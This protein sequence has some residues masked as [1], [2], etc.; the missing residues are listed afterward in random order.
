MVLSYRRL[1]ACRG[2]RVHRAVLADVCRGR[3]RVPR[4]ER[5]DVEDRHSTSREK[6]PAAAGIGRAAPPARFE[7]ADP[8]TRAARAERRAQHDDRRSVK[9]DRARVI[10]CDMWAGRS[11]VAARWGAVAARLGAVGDA[12]LAVDVGEVGLDGLA[13]HQQVF[14][15]YPTGCGARVVATPRPSVLPNPRVAR[16]ARALRQHLLYPVN[17]RCTPGGPDPRCVLYAL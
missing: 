15:K 16:G 5:R 10:R 14:A 12:E 7:F 13:A 3:H 2:A 8:R 4:D 11:C 1:D 6:A 9:S 17:E